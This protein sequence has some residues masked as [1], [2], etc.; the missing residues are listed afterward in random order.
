MIKAPADD[1]QTAARLCTNHQIPQMA[2]D[3]KIQLCYFGAKMIGR[4]EK[5]I[6]YRVER[7]PTVAGL[8]NFKP[9][10]PLAKSRLGKYDSTET[11]TPL[12]MRN[13]IFLIRHG[14]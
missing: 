9:S 3:E 6:Y 14:L 8:D 4:Q 2:T 11:K 7:R 13:S 1:R 10:R 12:S 5:P